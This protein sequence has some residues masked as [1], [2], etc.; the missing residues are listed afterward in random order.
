M[1]IADVVTDFVEGFVF[2][3]ALMLN[4]YGAANMGEI[5]FHR[6]DGD[7]LDA[8]GFVPPVAFS[9]YEGKRGVFAVRRANRALI[10]G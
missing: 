3:H 2:A 8:P 5:H 9:R 6:L 10:L 1:P 7:T 4:S